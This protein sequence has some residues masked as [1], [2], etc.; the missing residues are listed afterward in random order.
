MKCLSVSSRWRNPLETILT[1]CRLNVQL[2]VDG[3]DGISF[4]EAA[5]P[6]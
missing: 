3:S 2:S 4:I 1:K 6:S 5:Q